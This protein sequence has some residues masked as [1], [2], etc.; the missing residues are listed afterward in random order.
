MIVQQHKGI[1][2]NIYIPLLGAPGSTFSNSTTAYVAQITNTAYSNFPVGYFNNWKRDDNKYNYI[3]NTT[4]PWMLEVVMRNSGSGTAYAALYNHLGSVISGSEIT[5]S[6]TTLRYLT[7]SFSSTAA[8]FQDGD[9]LNLRARSGTSTRSARLSKAGLW[10]K[11]DFLKNLEIYN[12]ISFANLPSGISTTFLPQARYLWE[13]SHWSHPFVFFESFGII[14]TSSASLVNVGATDTGTSGLDVAT[15]QANSAYGPSRVGPIALNDGDSYIVKHNAS[16]STSLHGAGFLIVR[17]SET[18]P[19]QLALD[20][21]FD[22]SGTVEIGQ[23]GV[24]RVEN[25]SGTPPYFF[26]L[27]GPGSIVSNGGSVDYT[28]PA[29]GF[30]TS[31][32]SVTDSSLPPQSTSIT[33]SYRDPSLN[34]FASCKQAYNAGLSTGMVNLDFDGVGPRPARDFYCDMTDPNN[35]KLYLKQQTETLDNLRAVAASEPGNTGIIWTDRNPAN[36]IK[37]I[38]MYPNPTSG[39]GWDIRNISLAG[40]PAFKNVQIGVTSNTVNAGMGA[41]QLAKNGVACFYIADAWTG[42]RNM[43]TIVDGVTIST[44]TTQQNGTLRTALNCNGTSLDIGFGRNVTYPT[45]SWF[46]IRELIITEE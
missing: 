23:T 21:G 14:D 25:S 27:N 35:I 17:A 12:K 44:N 2:T 19:L 41:F 36:A 18:V 15:A 16:G 26:T 11:L 5:A 33:F 9:I 4:N 10:L 6:S 42:S 37:E 13:E 24:I 34:T 32:V 28:P 20:T 30:G 31:S 22:L 1:A 40:L 43:Q 46:Y 7:K 3:D 45:M 8:N 29:S 39:S 38:N